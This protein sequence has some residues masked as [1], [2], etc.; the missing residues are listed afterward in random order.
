MAMEEFINEF[1]REFE[2]MSDGEKL[3]ADALAHLLDKDAQDY[4]EALGGEDSE[5]MNVAA[6]SDDCYK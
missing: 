2:N 6:E 3:Y 1:D 5:S 4:V